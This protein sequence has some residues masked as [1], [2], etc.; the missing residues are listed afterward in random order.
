MLP[1]YT[2]N[3]NNSGL[4]YLRPKKRLMKVA[5]DIILIKYLKF[6]IL[7]GVSLSDP[8]SKYALKYPPYILNRGKALQDSLA[9][10]KSN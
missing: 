1:R 4:E 2:Y 9:M 5:K 3:E 7:P 6:K 8:I 10:P